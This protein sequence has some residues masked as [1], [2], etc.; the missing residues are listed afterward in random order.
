MGGERRAALRREGAEVKGA[1]LTL[2]ATVALMGGLIGGAY[3]TGM[4]P[5]EIEQLLIAV[6]WDAMFGSS[7]FRYKNIRRKD[8]ARDYP[9]RIEFG[10]KRG[11]VPP[12]SLNN[13]R[14]A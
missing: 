9:S 1:L 5:D 8:D 7:S 14:S 2:L 13:W 10:L 6:D 12:P 4:S 3:A 11:I